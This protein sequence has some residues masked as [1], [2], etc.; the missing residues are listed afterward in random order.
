M[1]DDEIIELYWRRQESAIRQSEIKY[2]TCCFTLAR[3]I[4]QNTEDAEEVVGDTWM[5]AWGSIPPRRPER[6]G[7]YLAK[8]TRNLAINK[9]KARG[10]ARRGGGETDAVL[11]EL[12]ECIAAPGSIEDEQTARELAES[13]RFFVRALPEREGNLFVRR[14]FFSEPIPVIAERFGLKGHNVTV[15]LSR[16]RRKLRRYLEKEGFLDE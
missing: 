14:Y 10:A 2:G 12:G 11:H 13:I 16:A 4:L 6:L 3:N 8:I 1:R 15:I 7:P 9:L 5:R